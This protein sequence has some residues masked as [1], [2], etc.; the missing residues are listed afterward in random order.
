VTQKI[1]KYSGLF[2]PTILIIGIFCLLFHLGKQQVSNDEAAYAFRVG[3]T[4]EHMTTILRQDNYPYGYFIYLK[5]WTGLFG[6]GIWALRL[7]SIPF[8]ILT[9][10]VY[11][12]YFAQGVEEKYHWIAL[13]LLTFSPLMLFCGRLA[14]YYA[15]FNFSA[16]LALG[17]LWYILSEKKERP[18]RYFSFQTILFSFSL[19]LLIYTHYL[20]IVLWGCI[21]VW[22]V[23]RWLNQKDKV[24]LQLLGVMF[25][26]GLFYLPQCYLLIYRLVEGSGESAG[27]LNTP[28][29]RRLIIQFAYTAYGFLFGHTLEMSRLILVGVG[30]ITGSIPFFFGIFK[31]LV[32]LRKKNRLR[33]SLFDQF[34]VFCLYFLITGTIFSYIIMWMFLGRN[35]P[36]MDY[37]ERFCFLLPL[38]IYLWGYG[39]SQLFKVLQ[40]TVLTLYAIPVS[41]SL[42]FLFTQSENNKWEFLIPWDQIVNTVESDSEKNSPIIIVDSWTMGSRGWYYFK[43]AGDRYI[44]L[45]DFSDKDL[46]IPLASQ[47]SAKNQ[48]V[49]LLKTTRDTSPDQSTTFLQEQLTEQFGE[50]CDQWTYVYDSASLKRLK[51]FA[52]RGT[53]I[54]TH[55]G[56]VQLVKFCRAT[57][58]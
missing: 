22:L 50:P 44:S 33:T 11:K 9:W 24:S 6:I 52:R 18:F 45:R 49:F 14:K 25:I 23:L 1:T 39:F 56:K 38:V 10:V 17:L 51:E 20:G 5:I 21:S 12:K 35:L 37:G 32:S 41:L 36:D 46:Y 47:L 13:C 42:F 28:D 34:P 43:D 26:T 48:N 7:S 15:V 16:L 55:Q 57:D 58:D 31:T 29:F 54:E 4:W 40:V 53:N 2:F 27:T 3:G 19:L 8:A 30:T